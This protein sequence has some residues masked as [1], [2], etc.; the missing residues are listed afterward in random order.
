MNYIQKIKPE[1]ELESNNTEASNWPNLF[2]RDFV[3]SG[4]LKLLSAV[5]CSM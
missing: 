1:F 5:Y 4:G 3:D 2:C